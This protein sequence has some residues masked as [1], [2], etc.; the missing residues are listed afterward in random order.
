MV[1]AYDFRHSCNFEKDFCE[2]TQMSG[3][4]WKRVKGGV[5]VI[6]RDHTTNGPDGHFLY[7]DGDKNVGQKSR[8]KSS[9][10]RASTDGSCQ[11]LERTFLF[12]LSFR[13]LRGMIII[14]THFLY[15]NQ[16]NLRTKA[17]FSR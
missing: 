1:L 14:Y 7:I 5:V 6:E 13:L 17:F 4:P 15:K 11:V 3:L 8:I 16:H 2:W 10:F 12:V 9:V